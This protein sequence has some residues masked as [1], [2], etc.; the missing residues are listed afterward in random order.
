MRHLI[1]IAKRN[2][3]DKDSMW[4][5]LDKISDGKANKKIS[6]LRDKKKV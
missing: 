5:W 4:L 1:F 3:T 6:F 2:C